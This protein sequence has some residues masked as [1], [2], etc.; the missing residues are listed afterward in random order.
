MLLDKRIQYLIAGGLLAALFAF[1]I[2]YLYA[3]EDLSTQD[4]NIENPIPPTEADLSKLPMT[5]QENKGQVDEVVRFLVKNS[6]TTIF[7]TPE[8]VVY[9]II[10]SKPERR[11]GPRAHPIDEIGNSEEPSVEGVVIRQKFVESNSGVEITGET[12]L[13]GKVNYFIGNKE[14]DWIKEASTFSSIRYSG[15]YNDID[16]IYSGSNSQLKYEYH[17]QPNQEPGQIEVLVEGVDQ[18]V[19]NPDGTMVFQTEVG[20]IGQP[21]PHAYQMIDGE[22]VLI[23]VRYELVDDFGY[24]FTLGEY[25]KSVELLIAS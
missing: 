24:K 8:E 11:K 23:S 10:T 25:D 15:L 18:V 1:G 16:L 14:E 6:S 19:I 12:G 22:Q 7:F 13:E 21:A 5:F 20:N 4:T 9:S 2:F 3:N 17:I